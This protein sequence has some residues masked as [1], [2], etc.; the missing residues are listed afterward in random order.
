MR[1]RAGGQLNVEH[2]YS[3]GNLLTVTGKGNY[4]GAPFMKRFVKCFFEVLTQAL[5]S[6]AGNGAQNAPVDV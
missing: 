6:A 3:F 1:D 5:V 2:K 4:T